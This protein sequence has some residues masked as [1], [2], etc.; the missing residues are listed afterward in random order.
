[1]GVD[2]R[3]GHLEE[4]MNSEKMFPFTTSSEVETV[5]IRELAASLGVVFD[6]EI[7][8]SGAQGTTVGLQ[9]KNVLL[10]YRVDSRTYFVHDTRYG[11]G[12]GLGV[13]EAN[14]DVYLRTASEL[15]LE[16]GIPADEVAKASVLTTRTQTASYDHDAGQAR[17]EEIRP[18][19]R[20]AQLTRHVA[21]LPVWSSR[22]LLGLAEK[23]QIGFLEAHWPEIPGMVIEEARR[24]AEMVKAGWRAPE[25]QGSN[26]ESVEAGII[27]SPAAGF[28]MDIYAVI[29]VVYAT[30]GGGKK[31]VV[32]LDR[33]GKPVPIPRA[34]D[35]PPEVPPA[36]RKR[37]DTVVTLKS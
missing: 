12:G 5:R 26:V 15:L 10:S 7:V 8:R 25:N 4:G 17:L 29:R 35:L 27:H 34:F 13:S 14:D 21:S 2:L 11:H 28:L 19:R 9:S 1:M 16:L 23:G 3:L 30:P 22:V 24:L 36:P 33:H 6:E 37:G 31:P 20:Y 32:Y 18:G